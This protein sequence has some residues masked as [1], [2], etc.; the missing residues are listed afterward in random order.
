MSWDEQAIVKNWVGGVCPTY[1]QIPLVQHEVIITPF[2][3]IEALEMNFNRGC[4]IKYLCRAGRKA[5]ELEDLKKARNCLDREI[6]RLTFGPETTPETNPL[7]G[8]Y[9][10]HKDKS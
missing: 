8:Q 5:S 9:G 3:I 1:Y 6:S 7:N 2:D 4:A 10:P